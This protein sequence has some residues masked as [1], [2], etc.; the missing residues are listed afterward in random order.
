[1]KRPRIGNL[2]SLAALATLVV[3]SGLSSVAAG[4]AL[5]TRRGQADR[6]KV[7]E[8]KAPEPPQ[9]LRRAEETPT[10]T[11]TQAESSTAIDPAARERLARTHE[12]H[13]YARAAAEDHIR[14]VGVQQYYRTGVWRGMRD[15]LANPSIG[16]WDHRIGRQVGR[17]DPR[18]RRQGRELG[19]QL[20]AEQGEVMA[21]DR[22]A[23][24]FHQLQE[25]PHFDDQP[26]LA[27]L[28]PESLPPVAAPTMDL[29]LG[30]LSF[31]LF[32]SRR[33]SAA[34][35]G[36]DW[37]PASLYRCDRFDRVYRNDWRDTAHAWNRWQ[38]RPS[39]RHWIQGFHFAANRSWAERTFRQHFN[40]ELDRLWEPLL[41]HAWEDGFHE[42]FELGAWARYEIA[43]REGFAI[44]SSEAVERAAGKTFND[45][46]P[47][48]YEES[49]ARTFDSWNTGARIE[50]DDIVFIDADDDGVFSPGEQLIAEVQLINYGGADGETGVDLDGQS[51]QRSV[52]TRT[53]IAARS[54]AQGALR[55][56]ATIDPAAVVRRDETLELGVGDRITDLPFRV[57]WPLEFAD[58]ATVLGLDPVLGTLELEIPVVNISRRSRGASLA[59]AGFDGT[60]NASLDPIAAGATRT[61]RFSIDGLSGSRLLDGNSGFTWSLTAE[62]HEQ[63]RRQQRLPNYAADLTS[64]WLTQ[65]MEALASGPRPSPEE[66]QRVHA[67]AWQRLESDWRRAIRRNNNP[68]KRD[69]KKKD[70]LTE[71]GDWVRR[72]QHGNQSEVWSG[73]GD[74]IITRSDTLPGAHPLLRKWLRRLAREIG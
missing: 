65:Y 64:P 43:W 38:E 62:G 29:V 46:F 12:L 2:L 61:V 51:L 67:L 16:V 20:A 31:A 25:N 68:Y 55:L 17:L 28:N 36:T 34:F 13:D 60:Q 49:Y 56:T 71:V 3:A 40:H 30:E 11:Q 26:P 14:R 48:H 63:D 42:G 4:D 47:V 57:A 53:K 41:L 35:S 19:E 24:Q 44:G 69:L 45:R 70:N 5:H 18:A 73:L 52:F 23:D 6:P 27:G 7:S 1:M 72:S 21:G 9:T 66:L 22:V 58:Q 59:L 37:T 39:H 74:L 8:K 50:L 54:R 15:A 33:L 32:S 10:A